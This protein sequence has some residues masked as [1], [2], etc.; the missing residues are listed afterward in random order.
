MAP[1]SLFRAA[2]FDD[3]AHR[4]LERAARGTR[5]PDPLITNQVLYQLSYGGAAPF[6]QHARKDGRAA[7]SLCPV[8][9]SMVNRTRAG[10]GR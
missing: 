9:L 8:R 2:V 3:A 10:D 1:A 6:C 4:R 5:T 7:N